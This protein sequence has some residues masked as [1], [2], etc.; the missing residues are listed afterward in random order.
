MTTQVIKGFDKLR[1]KLADIDR[2]IDAILWGNDD[3]TTE[4][5]ARHDHLQEKRTAVV[6]DL[7]RARTVPPPARRAA[8]GP[9]LSPVRRVVQPA[10]APRGESLLLDYAPTPAWTPPRRGA[11]SATS[12]TRPATPTRLPAYSQSWGRAYHEAGHAVA[13]ITLGYR[14]RSVSMGSPDGYGLSTRVEL[15]SPRDALT[16]ALAGRAG[17]ERASRL[18]LHTEP[19]RPLGDGDWGNAMAALDDAGFSRH[20]YEAAARNREYDQGQWRAEQQVKQH[21]SA[22][23]R[24]AETLHAR[25]ELTGS[26]VELLVKGV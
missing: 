25:G 3:L 20:P 15:G 2:E 11:Q 4:L 8:R 13:A 12:P 21:W 19:T 14:L 1:A 10:P 9:V 23:R 16:I 26:E 18:G 6:A 17:D 24:V 7:E 22:V 5:R